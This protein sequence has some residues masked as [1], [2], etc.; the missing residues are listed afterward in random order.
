MPVNFIAYIAS[1]PVWLD[2]LASLRTV[3][4]VLALAVTVLMYRFFQGTAN[5]HTQ[6]MHSKVIIITGGTSGIGAAVVHDLADRGAQLILLVRS[7]ADGWTQDY[8]Q[9]LRTQS[10]NDLIYAEECDSSSLYSI[11]KFAT[12]WIDNAPPRRVDQIIL[13]A[14]VIQPPFKPRSTTRDGAESQ[15]GVNFLANFQLLRILWPAINAQPADRDVRVIVA[16]CTSYI[17]GKVDLT[18]LDFSRR[19][20]PSR[21]P[22][23]VFGASKVLLMSYVLALQRKILDGKRPDGQPSRVKFLIVDPGLTRTQSLRRFI[24]CGTIIGL[25]GYLLTYPLWLF[26][27]KGP[28]R[29]AQ[30]ILHASMAPSMDVDGE[31]VMPGQI[32]QECRPKTLQRAEITD[33]KFQEDVIKV[34]EELVSSLELRTAKDKARDTQKRS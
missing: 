26:I 8:I 11:R 18:D 30:T 13:C 24:S 19:G 16:T 34:T 3:Y 21:T 32:L 29:G 4:T 28:G 15:L 20:Y 5:K 17:L 23:H 22:W 7:V 1:N 31:G 12:K 9:D 27:F 2:Q 25:L 14:G 10:G 6:D 33:T